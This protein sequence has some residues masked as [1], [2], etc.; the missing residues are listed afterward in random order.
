MLVPHVHVHARECMYNCNASI[1]PACLPAWHVCLAMPYHATSTKHYLFQRLKILSLVQSV[2]AQ[3]PNIRPL[4]F[5]RMIRQSSLPPCP[6]PCCRTRPS[7]NGNGTN[8]FLRL[9]V[10]HMAMCKFVLMD[11]Q[12]GGLL[13]VVF[14]FVLVCDG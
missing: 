9:L 3:T 8:S 11:L 12:K 14:V 6:C 7:P 10:Q 13:I 2:P 4:S 5:P 1:S